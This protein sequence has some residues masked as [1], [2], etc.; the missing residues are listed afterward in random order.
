MSQSTA[1]YTELQH[2]LPSTVASGVTFLLEILAMGSNFV[3]KSI[4]S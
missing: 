2:L 3:A 4:H 1:Y